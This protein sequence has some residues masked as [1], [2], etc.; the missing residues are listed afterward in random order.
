MSRT[1]YVFKKDNS[2]IYKYAW[3]NAITV[4][5]VI[6]IKIL[7]LTVFCRFIIMLNDSRAAF[8]VGQLST[9]LAPSARLFFHP[10]ILCPIKLFQLF[11]AFPHILLALFFRLC[12][13]LYWRCKIM[14]TNIVDILATFFLPSAI[15][16]LAYWLNSCN[17]STPSKRILQY[18]VHIEGADYEIPI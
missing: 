2:R 15:L 8:H 3:Q 10:D 18:R 12:Y 17:K 4:I 6:I 14:N 13:T 11:F 16:L 7:G 9:D 1:F 5:I